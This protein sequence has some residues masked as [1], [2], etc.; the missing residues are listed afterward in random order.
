MYGFLNTNDYYTYFTY[1]KN[2]NISLTLDA[3]L[4]SK[5]SLNILEGYNLLSSKNKINVLSSLIKIVFGKGIFSTRIDFCYMCLEN[6]IKYEN[7]SSIIIQSIIES[8]IISKDLLCYLNRIKFINFFDNGIFSNCSILDVLFINIEKNSYP[9]DIDNVLQTILYIITNFP[10]KESMFFNYKVMIIEQYLRVEQELYSEQLVTIFNKLK[11]ISLDD[12]DLMFYIGIVKMYNEFEKN[13]FINLES[14]ENI[15]VKYCGEKDVLY[16]FTDRFQKYFLSYVRNS[17]SLYEISKNIPSYVLESIYYPELEFYD[18]YTGEYVSKSLERM[19]DESYR[20]VISN[21]VH[22]Y[23]CKCDVNK[24]KI[25]EQVLEENN[26]KI[27]NMSSIF[28]IEITRKIFSL[29]R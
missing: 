28:P 11:E 10:Y 29:L 3:E 15:A 22:S 8:K 25:Y 26:K 20:Q 4:C 5:E 12:K 13:N 16:N 21:V 17:K 24:I 27:L 2:Y 1:H 18:D 7:N 9:F 6:I 14:F 19:D 23:K